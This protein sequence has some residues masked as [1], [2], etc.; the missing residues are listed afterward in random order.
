MYQKYKKNEKKYINIY[1]NMVKKD[2]VKKFTIIQ[3]GNGDNGEERKPPEIVR[4]N[5]RNN[6][7]NSPP[8]TNRLGYLRRL[9][10]GDDS[11]SNFSNN[12]TEG[13]SKELIPIKNEFMNIVISKENITQENIII[14]DTVSNKIFILPN[15]IIKFF[16]E[17][18]IL[19]LQKIKENLE[20]ND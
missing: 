14:P 1:N 13:D 3:L 18:E 6:S 4:L 8:R 5:L 17:Y 12:E 16:T 19:Y 15:K 7:S 11:S 2:N 9:N 20:T 10:F